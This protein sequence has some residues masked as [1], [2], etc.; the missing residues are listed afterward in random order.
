MITFTIPTWNRADKLKV[1]LDSILSQVVDGIKI[2]VYNNSSDD[3]TE[4]VLKAYSAKYPCIKY[5]TGTNHVKAQDS[6]RNAWLMA[7]TKFMWMFG[8]DDLLAT[9]GLATVMDVLKRKD[10]EFI[11]AAEFTRCNGENRT[12]F[13]TTLD[14]CSAFGFVEMT[15][16]ISGN[17]CK[18]D[19]LHEVLKHDEQYKAASYYQSLVILDALA[20]SK[21]A[22]INAPIVDLQERIQTNETCA[23]WYKE[24][25]PLH[26]VDIGDGLVFMRDKGRIPAKLSKDFFRYLDGNMFAKVLFNFY[27]HSV[28]Q[29]SYIEQTYWDKVD[30]MV[31]FLEDGEK[32]EK[33]IPAFRKSIE[34]YVDSLNKSDEILIMVKETHDPSN[35]VVYPFN[36]V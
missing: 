20:D 32:V 25:V 28:R 33:I 27:D 8:D 21:A 14:L 11:K 2:A 10:V 16:F 36:Y 30:K 18:T 29:K 12:Y 6:F 23:R 13:S 3:E 15:G 17:I 31:S 5:K 34:L 22:F 4:N 19:K 35:D 1:C 9:N 24:D 26:Y 7:E